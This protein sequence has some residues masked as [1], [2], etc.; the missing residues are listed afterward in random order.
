MTKDK[1]HRGEFYHFIRF[2]SLQELRLIFL[3]YLKLFLILNLKTEFFHIL[4]IGSGFPAARWINLAILSSLI[5]ENNLNLAF[6][7]T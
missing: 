6:V 4:S 1:S 5:G 7:A 2:I 3:I